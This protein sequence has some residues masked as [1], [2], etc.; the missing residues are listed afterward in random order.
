[1]A[2]GG[3]LLLIFGICCLIVALLDMDIHRNG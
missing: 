2:L 3:L 1:M